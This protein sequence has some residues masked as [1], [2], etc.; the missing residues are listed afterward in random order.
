MR[1]RKY[2]NGILKFFVKGGVWINLGP[3]LYHFSN[4]CDEESIEPSYDVVREV[5]E[6]FGFVFEVRTWAQLY[7]ISIIKIFIKVVKWVL[8]LK[9]KHLYYTHSLII[10][11][12]RGLLICLSICLSTILHL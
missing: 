1:R 8:V 3:L 2:I 6:G 9:N 5:I 4:I 12:R 10:Y 7:R 11:Y